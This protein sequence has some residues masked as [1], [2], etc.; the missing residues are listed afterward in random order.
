MRQM[1]FRF[2]IM[3]L[4]IL[5]MLVATAAQAQWALVAKRAI[6]RVEQ[7]SQQSSQ[8]GGPSYDSAAVMLEAPADKVFAAVLTGVR[9]NTR[10]LKITRE[11]P[12]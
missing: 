3:V 12:S 1:R 8:A 9:N 6:G 7:M 11:D 2:A 10:G 5:T 4:G